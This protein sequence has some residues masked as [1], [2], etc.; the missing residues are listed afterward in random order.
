MRNI[1]GNPG[2]HRGAWKTAYPLARTPEW[3][4]AWAQME[5]PA[6]SESS[7]VLIQGLSRIENGVVAQTAAGMGGVLQ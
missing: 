4:V 1:G 7:D 6:A 2:K 3:R 5:L